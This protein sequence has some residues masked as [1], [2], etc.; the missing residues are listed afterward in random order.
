MKLPDF[1]PFDTINEAL[2]T[3]TSRQGIRRV[4][5]TPLYANALYLMLSTIVMTLC[6]F[7]FWLVVARFYSEAVVGYS[8]AI[9]SALNL[10]AVLGLVGLNISLVRFLPQADNPREMM[11]T[12]FTLGGLVSLVA[13]GIFLTGLNVW[14]PALG[15][16]RENALFCLAFLFFAVLWTLSPLIDSAFLAERRAGF[17]LSKNTIFS[18]LKIPLPVLLALY[19]H[20]FGVVAS[21]GI[22]LG[23]ALLV[24][25]LVFLPR[26]RAGYRPVP[27]LNLGLVKKQWRYS[28]GNYLVNLLLVAPG[29]L[30][31]LMVV[32]LLGAEQNAYFYIA[33]M[34]AG[35]LLAIPGAASSSLFAEGSHFEGRLRENVVKSLKSSF[36]LLVPAAILLAAV[37][38]WLLL[39][40]GHGY[41][42]NALPLLW[43]LCASSLPYGV[44]Y[45]YTTI[46]RVVGRITEL[47][48]IWGFIAIGTLVVGYLLLPLTGIVGIGYA[49]LGAQLIVAIYILVT[50]KLLRGRGENVAKQADHL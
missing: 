17:T 40:F 13:A 11:N 42:L 34:M 38:K 21:W 31:P 3:A 9:I 33:W 39:A 37:G 18:L 32:N 15:F 28:S 47:I 14:S 5:T 6:G 2:R 25:L 20:S 8:S 19:F 4:L 10:L 35:L 41:S 44:N 29:Y 24:A 27:A 46:L 48:I 43:V 36:L 22:A 30:L 23:V 16:V 7:F 50:R 45:I 1:P 49:W 12:C 26:V